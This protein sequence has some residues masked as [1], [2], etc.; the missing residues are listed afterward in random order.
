ML[1]QNRENPPA[2]AC[3]KNTAP[4]LFL[5]AVRVR[6]FGCDPSRLIYLEGQPAIYFMEQLKNYRIDT[7][8]DEA[9]S[10]IAKPLTNQEIDDLAAWHASIQISIKTK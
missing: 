1:G 4:I 2:P 6:M 9:I 7:R 8:Q 3:Q 5:R 10:V